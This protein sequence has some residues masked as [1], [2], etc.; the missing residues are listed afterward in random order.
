MQ[1]ARKD[2]LAAVVGTEEV[3]VALVDAEEVRC[4]GQR[5]KIDVEGPAGQ[6]E[7]DVDQAVIPTLDEKRQVAA[8]VLVDLRH[9]AEVR[10]APPRV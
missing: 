1:S 7:L 3:D 8:L 9:P 6:V 5:L 10:L 2:V 4:Q